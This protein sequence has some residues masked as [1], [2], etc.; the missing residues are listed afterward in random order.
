MNL[1]H[2]GLLLALCCSSAL[3]APP[4][5][6]GW[7]EQAK[8]MPENALLKARLDTGVQTSVMDAR[9]IVRVKKNDQRWVQYDIVVKDPAS[10]K[11]VSYPYE[12]PIE[13]QLKVRGAEGFEHRPV[14][15]MDI[16]LGDKVYREQFALSDREGSE[17][18]LILGR[19]ALEHLGA[20]DVSKTLTVPP[21]CKP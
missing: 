5:I 1:R 2:A 3:A 16:C 4:T 17:Y 14:V 9:N 8:L 6:W 13:R 11:A 20:V 10:G 12:R 18:P 7:V 19:R 15:S 21:T